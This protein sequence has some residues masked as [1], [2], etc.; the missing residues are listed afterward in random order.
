VA[1]PSSWTVISSA[2]KLSSIKD[3]SAIQNKLTEIHS[4]SFG[5]PAVRAEYSLHE[6][7]KTQEIATY[8]FAIYAGNF[9]EIQD[10]FLDT[11]ENLPEMRILC[12]SLVEKSVD[13][14][15]IFKTVKE[16]MKWFRENL[17]SV[18]P[19]SKVDIVFLPDLK[20]KAVVESVGCITIDDFFL[21]PTLTSLDQA[22]HHSYLAR[23]VSLNYFGNYVT[24]LW[25]DDMWLSQSLSIFLSFLALQQISERLPDEMQHFNDMWSIFSKYKTKAIVFDQ[26]RSTHQVKRLIEDTSES[27]VKNDEISFYKGISILKYYYYV[28]GHELFFKGLKNYVSK[29][30]GKNASYEQFKEVLRSI[31][32]NREEK[33]PLE[34]IE[35][36]LE[37]TGLVKLETAVKYSNNIIEEFTITQR[38]C[39]H[40]TPDTYY[41][42]GFN[43][44]LIYPGKEVLLNDMEI[45]GGKQSSIVS[46]L[47][48][49]EKPLAVVLNAGDWAYFK[50]IFDDGS[51]KYLIEH[52]HLIKNPVDR[53]VVVR[54]VFEMIREGLV[55]VDSFVAFTKNLLTHEANAAVVNKALHFAI[56]AVSNFLIYEKQESQKEI[57]FSLI[58][59]ELFTKFKN[60][61]LTLINYLIDLINFSNDKEIRFL[62]NFLKKDKVQNNLLRGDSEILDNVDFIRSFDLSYIDV[63]TKMR[64]LETIEESDVLNKE[65]KK[66]F[67]QMIRSIEIFSASRTISPNTS[68][69]ENRSQTKEDLLV[70]T[71]HKSERLTLDA[72]RPDR[73]NK[74][75]IWDMLV[76][77]DVLL[78]D[79]EY[80][81]IMKGFAR[82]SQYRLLKS[83]FKYRFFEDFLYVKNYCG[84]KYAAMFFE[85]LNPGFVVNEK[86]LDGFMKLRFRI[87]ADEHKLL[88]LLDKSNL[89]FFKFTKFS[90]FLYNLPN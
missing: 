45:S 39:A 40:A 16:V 76:N 5:T 18:Y 51:L 9:V 88:S 49:L 86:V 30:H 7:D 3:S 15:S 60:I 6:F 68:Q 4:S 82:K 31:T 90:I 8:T 23:A 69:M 36:F 33:T 83:Y 24:P 35:P 85:H 42:L 26:Y 50:Q 19:D 41:N 89:I 55:E 48:G 80:E 62:I 67:E 37:N 27:L 84:E 11:S 58:K 12:R 46:E 59:D 34:I 47:A 43:I 79:E 10:S 56:Y 21:E 74:E 65:E 28:A 20:G 75:K 61:R 52:A 1:C 17:S 70:K 38:P 87:K 2:N 14:F 29:Y 78:L 57:L 44:L 63:K 13:E 25:W 32:E 77:K 54:D 71:G 22:V 73:A 53:L 72:C 66:Q 64:L 81:A